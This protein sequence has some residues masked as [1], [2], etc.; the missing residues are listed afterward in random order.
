MNGALMDSRVKNRGAM[1]TILVTRLFLTRGCPARIS[2][3]GPT[4]CPA[5]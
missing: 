1:M 2:R 5:C 3:P 4:I